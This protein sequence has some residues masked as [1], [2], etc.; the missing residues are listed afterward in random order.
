MFILLCPQIRASRQVTS[1]RK[2]HRREGKTPR[3]INI[4]T[5]FTIRLPYTWGHISDI[6]ET[7]S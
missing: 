2:H 7:G 4:D 6:H 5:N 1:V 3:I